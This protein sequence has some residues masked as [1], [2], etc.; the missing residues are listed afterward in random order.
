MPLSQVIMCNSSTIQPV[1]AVGVIYSSENSNINISNCNIT[2]NSVDRNG[3]GGVAYLQQDTIIRV[4]NTFIS[5]N[6]AEHG[7]VMWAQ[8]S[9]IETI[10]VT[11]IDNSAN[12]DGGV[13][14]TDQSHTNI[15]QNKFSNNHADNN[16]GTVYADG[17]ST[18]IVNSNFSHNSAGSD[19]AVMR[20]YLNELMLMECDF[21]N[22]YAVYEGGVLWTDQCSLNV[23]ETKF[24]DN[25]ADCGGAIHLEMGDTVLNITSFMNNTANA[26]GALWASKANITSFSTNITTNSAKLSVLYLLSSN[27]VWSSITLSDNIGSMLSQGSVVIIEGDSFFVNNI[28]PP[29]TTTVNLR[30]QGGAITSVLQSNI[31]LKGICQFQNNSAEK[32]GALN[33]VRSIVDVHDKVTIA[34]N[35]A[36][37]CG[38]GVHKCPCSEER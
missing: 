26:G 30:L 38:G 32:G 35:K 37:V 6:R 10:N 31:T 16:G 28:Q 9:T 5:R 20:A 8:R 13:F 22:N 3:Y 36:T 27:T 11:F 25:I 23:I 18:R 2:L 21:N 34:M 15:P 33:I 17:G 14:Y 19:G 7:G 29:L 12:S 4:F 1:K 24:A